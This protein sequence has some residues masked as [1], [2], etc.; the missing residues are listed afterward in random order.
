M[1]RVLITI[2]LLAACVALQAQNLNPVVE[3]TNVYAREATGIEKPNQLLSLP[4]SVYKFDL[5]FDYTVKS[6]PYKGA[7]EFNPYLVQ[8]R[9]SARL[10]GEQKLY[11][12]A[13]VGYR[14]H[15]EVDF[16]WNPLRTKNFRLD[17][18]ATHNSYIG[19]YRNITVQENVVDWDGT[20]RD[21]SGI[22]SKTSVGTDLW[23]AF[24]GG[25]FTANLQYRNILAT[26]Y[27]GYE[28]PRSRTHNRGQFEA[29]VQNKPTAKFIYNVGTRLAI[30]GINTTQEFHT[31]SDATLGFRMG[32]NNS[33]RITAGLET[34][35]FEENQ[36]GLKLEVTPHYQFSGKRFNLDLGVKYSY[37]SSSPLAYAYKGGILFPDVNFSFRLADAAVVYAAATGGDK[38]NCKD[39]LLEDNPYLGGFSWYRDVTVTRIN[40]FGGIRGSVAGKFSYDLRGGWKWLDNACGWSFIETLAPSYD[41]SSQLV[42]V[43]EPDFLVPTMAYVSPLRTVYGQLT[44]S[45]VSAS[46]DIMARG[47]YG[48]TPKPDKET[49]AELNVFGPPSFTAAGHVFYKWANR[50]KVG[51]TIET[52][53]KLNARR[54]VPGYQDLGFQ[55]DYA[56]SR[57]M[58]VWFKLGNILNQTIQK[59]PFYAEA[60]IYGSVGIKLT[61]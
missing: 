55:A 31:V 39:S 4:D 49:E 13:G 8:L 52:R 56:F 58:A 41:P 5:D 38:L 43:P 37:I 48:H 19:R 9:P 29:R 23:A 53:S 22:C 54:P 33:L 24:K 42:D 32:R 40:V 17:V 1:K 7:Y 30:L 60:G 26:D 14:M 34:V 15:P 36:S 28:G 44:L 3:V 61:F 46:W 11:L 47:Y 16:V 50:I 10:S 25:E 2:S 45:W 51:A 6:T 57:H 18:Y 27:F 21:M 12:K 35:G 59:T 20:M